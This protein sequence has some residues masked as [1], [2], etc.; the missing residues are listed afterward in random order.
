MEKNVTEFLKEFSPDQLVDMKVMSSHKRF[1]Y[2]LNHNNVVPLI[3]LMLD[4]GV[5]KLVS[6]DG[7]WFLAIEGT[8]RIPCRAK[9]RVICSRS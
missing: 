4:R 1:R 8:F 7:R 9:K 2:L 3:R 5:T 6:T